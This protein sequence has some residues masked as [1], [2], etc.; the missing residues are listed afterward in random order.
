MRIELERVETLELLG[1]VLAHL[2]DAEA[3]GDMSPRI[4]TLMSIRD[5][6]ATGLRGEQ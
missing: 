4:A 2:N 3:A 6:L 5:K 1:M